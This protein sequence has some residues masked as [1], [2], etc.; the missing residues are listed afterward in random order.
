M[1]VARRCSLAVAVLAAGASLIGLLAPDVYRDQEPIRSGW[2]ASDAVTLFLVVPIMLVA[3]HRASDAAA[4]LVLLGT[5]HYTLYG[6]AFYLFGA[7]L[8]A[9]LPLYAAIVA[10]SIG[11][12]AITLSTSDAPALEP[13]ARGVA[14]WM[15]FVA[16]GLTITWIAQWLVALL[17]T[18]APTRFDLTPEFVRTTAALD[19]TLMVAWLA[20]G[21]VLLW[22]R[23]VLGLVLGVALMVSGALY[24]VVLAAGTIVQARMG[25]TLALPMLG[26]WVALA[27]GCAIAAARLLRIARRGHV[28][29]TGTGTSLAVAVPAPLAP[30]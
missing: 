9:L 21:A 11:A 18:A 19:L 14:A 30:R 24:N 17:R 12:L 28:I 23:R 5:L 26:L 2:I 27:I 3:W 6:Y 29:A 7:T 16:T 20:V 1:L 22:R 15:S 4:R 13:R 25:M 10:C 8:N